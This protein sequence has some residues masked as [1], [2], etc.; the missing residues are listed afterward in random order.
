M[1]RN[2]VDITGSIGKYKNIEEKIKE[3]IPLQK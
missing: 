2:H 1:M 3:I